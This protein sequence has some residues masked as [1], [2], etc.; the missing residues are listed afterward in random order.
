MCTW[1]HICICILTYHTKPKTTTTTKQALYVLIAD[2]SNPATG[3]ATP[4][5]DALAQSSSSS[6][7]SLWARYFHPHPSA[8]AH[9]RGAAAARAGDAAVVYDFLCAYLCGGG[10]QQQQPQQHWEEAALTNGLRVVLHPVAVPVLAAEQEAAAA[11]E[12]E[13]DE[14]VE[15]PLLILRGA[16]LSLAEAAAVVTTAAAGGFPLLMQQEEEEGADGDLEA[17]LGMLFDGDDAH[18]AA[19]T[20]SSP[21]PELMPTVGGGR[22]RG[23]QLS[24]LV[25]AKQE[26]EEYEDGMGASVRRSG[27]ARRAAGRYAV[28]YADRDAEEEAEEESEAEAEEDEEEE[29]AAAADTGLGYAY[30]GKPEPAGKGLL[31]RGRHKCRV[32]GCVEEY[33]WPDYFC[34]VHGVSFLVFVCLLLEGCLCWVGG[35]VDGVTGWLTDWCTYT[36]IHTIVQGGRCQYMWWDESIPRCTKFHQ[37]RNSNGEVRGA[38]DVCVCVCWGGS[39][40]LC[41]HIYVDVPPEHLPRPTYLTKPHR[42]PTTNTQQTA[43]LRR[44]LPGH[45]GA[46]RGA[47]PQGQGRQQQG[48]GLWRLL[49]G[50]QSQ[51]EPARGEAQSVVNQKWG[52]CCWGVGSGRI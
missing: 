4:L 18:A 9:A 48:Q 1:D 14:G 49:G 5:L 32:P 29:E 13:E 27:R 44:A 15:A 24:R 50:R 38:C 16:S 34:K 12:V 3:A 40:Y 6:S 47:V 11:A 37:S 45:G 19:T 17:Q 39:V 52:C 21:A 8:G 42:Q 10:A 20:T 26:Q 31:D 25:S 35:W 28:D 7:S 23:K 43:P 51:E 46:L 36:H 30:P 41:V 22:G 33:R 2:P